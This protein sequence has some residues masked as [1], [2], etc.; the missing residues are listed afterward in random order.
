MGPTTISGMDVS[1]SR[2]KRRTLTLSVVVGATALAGCGD[3]DRV[4]AASSGS[5]VRVLS[6]ELIAHARRLGLTKD[7][8]TGLARACRDLA[9][10]ARQ[11]HV[12]RAVLCPPLVPSGGLRMRPLAS[13]AETTADLRPGYSIDVRSTGLPNANGGHWVFAA[14]NASA[15]RTQIFPPAPEAPAGQRP[16]RGARPI[17]TT[18]IQ[19]AGRP[20]VVYYMPRLPP[21]SQTDGPSHQLPTQDHTPMTN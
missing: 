11:Q 7:L 10:R 6:A 15:L 16:I 18:H 19:L 8:P 2:R 9:L 4:H 17:R 1:A 21:P 3:G 20:A 13:G 12:S 14:G 5:R